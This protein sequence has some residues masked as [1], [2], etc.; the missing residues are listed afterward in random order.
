MKTHFVLVSWFGFVSIASSGEMSRIV[1]SPDGADFVE[2]TTGRPFVPW[3]FNYD[4]DSRGRLIEDYW[5]DEWPLVEDHFREM[6]RL[7][8]NTVRVHLQLSRFMIGPMQCHEAN[9]RQLQRLLRLAESTGLYLNITG[10][11]C[12]HKAD[13]PAWYDEL[14]EQ[15]RWGVQERFWQTIASC[16]RDHPAVFCYDL[17]NEPVVPYGRR[18][19][20]D[21][22][23]PAFANKHFVQLI[24]LD[25]A[26]RPRYEIARSWIQRMVRAIRAVD[27]ERLIT[28]GLVDWS[29]DGPGMT[30]GF[31]P[32]KLTR[33]L[34][35]ISVHLYPAK[36]KIKEALTTLRGFCIG[37]PVLIEETFPLHCSQEEFASFIED[38]REWAAGWLGFYWGKSVE[39]LRPAKTIADAMML[40]W[41]EYFQRSAKGLAAP[42][43]FEFRGRCGPLKPDA[44]SY[45]PRRQVF[46]LRVEE[47]SRFTITSV[48]PDIKERNVILRI[49]GMLPDAEGPLTMYVPDHG[50]QKREYRLYHKGYDA[51]LFRIRR[52]SGVTTIEFLPKGR[53][54]LKPGVVFQYVD[55]YR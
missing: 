9:L 35:F 52:E 37:K 51:E 54:L 31:L 36:G 34:D 46:Q 28:V 13:V 12:Y 19:P 10:L 42:V 18:Q 23:G 3:G 11:G 55:F 27:K 16:C 1:V 43:E 17:M 47:V 6:R 2:K 48:V 45:D 21:W 14:N 30:S 8:A 4:H 40:Q 33:D 20:K 32:D 22:L 24:S 25:Q 29:L 7:G 50:G 38:S 49:V 41:L 44:P 53:E 26:G 15:D 39:E 5:I